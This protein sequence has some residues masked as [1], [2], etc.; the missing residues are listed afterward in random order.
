[1]LGYLSRSMKLH[2]I[3]CYSFL[4]VN[5]FGFGDQNCKISAIDN[6]VQTAIATTSVKVLVNS[7]P[8]R[9]IIRPNFSDCL[10]HEGVDVI[11][12]R[13]FITGN[14]V[15]KR[16][17]NLSKVVGEVPEFLPVEHRFGPEG[18]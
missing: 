3:L 15:M 12:R 5:H 8:C 4:D 18:S 11:S 2:K 17:C 7:Q 9:R 13:G 10:N 16:C 1:M 6:I 14:F